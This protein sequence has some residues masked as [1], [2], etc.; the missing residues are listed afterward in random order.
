[1]TRDCLHRQR[2]RHLHDVGHPHDAA[3]RH[4]V[5]REIEIKPVVERGVDGVRRVDEEQ[6]V[7]VGRGLGDRFRRDVAARARTVLDDEGLAEPLGEPFAEQTRQDVIGPACREA[8]HEAHRLVG[9]GLRQREARSDG[10]H[11]GAGCELQD[12]AAWQSHGSSPGTLSQAVRRS[13]VR[14]FTPAMRH[15]PASLS[16]RRRKIATAARS[17][18][19]WPFR[20]QHGLAF[21][22]DAR[23]LQLVEAHSPARRG[24]ER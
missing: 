20:R 5:G 13:I 3:D 12:R 17:V 7:A 19:A 9:V 8:D 21:S 16:V 10:Q 6:R 14:I 23:K 4:D 2:R 24:L 18:R 15:K 1:M 11:S 22:P